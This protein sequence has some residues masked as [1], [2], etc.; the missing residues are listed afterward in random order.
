M[1]DVTYICVACG[2]P[3]RVL[4]GSQR[5]YCSVCLTIRVVMGRPKD[6]KEK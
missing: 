2:V 5:K 6:E 4:Q 3:F 1:P